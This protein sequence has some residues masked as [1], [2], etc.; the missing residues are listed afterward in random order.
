MVKLIVGVNDLETLYPEIS[1]EWNYEKNGDLKP[2]DITS[3]SGKKV[4]W[5]C[6]FGHIYQTSV[7]SRNGYH[8]QGCPICAKELRTS[9]SEQALFYYIRQYYTNA[10]NSD[11]NTIG[12]ELDIY[13]PSLRTAVEYDGIKW[14]KNA[15]KR[16]LKKNRLCNN[17]NILL[18]RVR[19][20]GLCLYDD[21][22]C[23]IRTD[24]KSDDGLAEVIR[25]VLFYINPD[26]KPDID[27]KRDHISI[28]SSYITTCKEKS[29]S[30]VYPDIAKEWHLVKNGNITP[31]MVSPSSG[32]TFWWHCRNGHEWQARVYSRIKCGCPYCSGKRAIK[33]KTDL[34]TLYPDIA[35]E[36]H[37]TKNGKLQPND[38]TAKSGKKVW[39][40]GKCGHEWQ[41]S[42]NERV[43][44]NTNCPYCANKK[45]LIGFNDLA[46]T[47]PDI[48]AQWNPTKNGDLKPC[49]VTGKSGKKVWW[50]CE[51]G[52]EWIASVANKANGY[53]CPYCCDALAIKGETDL[54]T[55]YPDIASEWHPKL[56]GKL[57][58][59]EMTAKSGKKV[60]WLCSVCNYEWQAVIGSRTTNGCG[61]PQCGNIRKGKAHQKPVIC[62]DTQIK[63]SNM[64]EAA[65]ITNISYKSLN[66]CCRGKSKTAGGFHWKY[67]DDKTE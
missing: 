4:W 48:A 14:H 18:V 25:K 52:H 8:H 57:R 51:N 35:A 31:D 39:W 60:W 46:T 19:E 45:V 43:G 44:H 32:K 7:A 12:M 3:H 40:L 17:N 30:A 63:Y 22:C 2:C 34:A 21:C 56:N 10:I 28:Y 61:C 59:I 50:K 26:L 66:N 5:K 58:P 54:Q 49:D 29:L 33:G 13:I 41:I 64:K 6:P 24:I 42:A 23:I 37:P 47:N 27:I 55:L 11:L 53:G 16:E 1:K 65:N 15:E 38:M 36:W 67:C 20:N 62:V 9:F